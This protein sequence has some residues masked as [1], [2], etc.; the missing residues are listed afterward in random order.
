MNSANVTSS[1]LNWYDSSLV[2]VYVCQ[3]T[4]QLKPAINNALRRLLDPI[5]NEFNASP[6]WQEVSSTFSSLSPSP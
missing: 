5:Q 3:L 6:E 1:L 2:K 4:S